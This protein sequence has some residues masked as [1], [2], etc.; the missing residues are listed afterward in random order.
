[1]QRVYLDHNA[2]APE[3]PE[4]AA[5]RASAAGT[6]NP[7]SI[8]WAGRRAREALDLARERTAE[9]LGA[10]P[11]DLIFTSG[12]TEANALALWGTV[13]GGD[14]ARRRVLLSA[15]EHPSLLATA[16]RLVSLGAHVERLPVGHDGRIDLDRAR[17]AMGSDVLLV[18]LMLAN[19]ETGALQPV[20]EV[21]EAAHAC[22]ALL[23]C[24]AA[25]AAGRAEVKPAA[26]GADLLSLSGHKL[27][28]GHGAGLLWVRREIPL[29][30]LAAGHQEGGRRAG[31]EDVPA[32][33]AF[34]AALA[35]AEAE[36]PRAVP[37]MARLQE[38]L[39]VVL[40]AASWAGTVASREV[41]RLPNTT[42]VCFREATG[43]A[44]LIALDLAGI[45][46]SSGPAC[47]S[48][49]LA[50]SH[51]LLAM[52]LP[53]TLARN[54]VRFSWGPETTEDDIDR[55]LAVLPGIVKAAAE[56]DR[57]SGSGSETP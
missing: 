50:P 13:L 34:A 48:G 43:E 23:H 10:R 51:V 9:V 25:Q 17:A 37:R 41:P 31:T 44:V 32:C 7:S 38:R 21:A 40:R 8:H 1:M 55:L 6:G 24:D 49:T 57:I 15:V 53:E 54:S 39:E 47:A 46:A 30:G 56:A 33:A 26:L 12:A 27:G 42:C 36:R 19:N 52:G 4:A 45:A 22:G 18:S 35:A 28:A 20:A 16:D 5:A 29:L 2:S 3:R 11:A 14:P